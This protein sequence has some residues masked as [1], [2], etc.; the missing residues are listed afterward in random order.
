MLEPSRDGLLTGHSIFNWAFSSPSALD[1][2]QAQDQET[3]AMIR[4]LCQ[5]KEQ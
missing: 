2:E 5:G 3:T 4:H 1:E